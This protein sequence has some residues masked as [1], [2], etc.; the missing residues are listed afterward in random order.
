MLDEDIG[1]EQI[2]L[3]SG[4]L[5]GH[6]HYY[7]CKFADGTKGSIQLLPGANWTFQASASTQV[8]DQ[9]IHSAERAHISH[10]INLE[11][12]QDGKIINNRVYRLP[13]INVPQE[14][15]N[16]VRPSRV[17]RRRRKRDD[18]QQE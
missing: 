9:R 1:W 7:K 18:V 14:S 10:Q 4:K 17:F 12:P 13:E 11:I 8:N 15:S 16:T 2:V 5:K 6:P 3:T